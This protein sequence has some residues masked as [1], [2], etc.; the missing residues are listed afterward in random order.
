MRVFD[1]TYLLEQSVLYDLDFTGDFMVLVEGTTIFIDVCLY[2]DKPVIIGQI[3]FQTKT[4][5]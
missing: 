2:T 5:L 4:G 1:S 3:L